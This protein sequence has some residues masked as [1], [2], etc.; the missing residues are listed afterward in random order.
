MFTSINIE[1]PL[2][3]NPSWNRLFFFLHRSRSNRLILLYLCFSSSFFFS[4]RTLSFFDL[5]L[6]VRSDHFIF[7]N[8]FFLS[9]PPHFQ[10]LMIIPHFS[11]YVVF[12]FPC[13]LC[14][15]MSIYVHSSFGWECSVYFC[16]I[17]LKFSLVIRIC[18]GVLR[19]SVNKFKEYRPQSQEK[20]K[21]QITMFL[22]KWK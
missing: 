21:K 17:F 18:V 9:D 11:W 16:L 5:F 14:D 15:T 19:K 1:L 8:C 2:F 12:C 7:S 22:L 4:I 13:Y 6:I 20:N 3:L 10:F